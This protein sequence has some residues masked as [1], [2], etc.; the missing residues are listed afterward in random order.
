[1]TNSIPFAGLA[2]SVS[3]MMAGQKTAVRINDTVHVSP[4]MYALMQ[5]ATPED[6]EHL[7]RNL[8]ILDLSTAMAMQPMMPMM[9][10]PLER[11]Y[12]DEFQWKARY[13]G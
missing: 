2:I 10:E 4:A 11:L 3:E 6:L 1:M 5:N 9:T 8:E 7:F 12:A 13:D